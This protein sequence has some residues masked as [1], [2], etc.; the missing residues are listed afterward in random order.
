MTAL[1]H[2]PKPLQERLK[3]LVWD[4]TILPRVEGRVSLKAPLFWFA[5]A[6][7]GRMF[8][9]AGFPVDGGWEDVQ[10]FGRAHDD[11]L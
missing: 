11:R 4:V 9:G 5:Q 3:R 6:G 1:A 2:T 10:F 7:S 8:D